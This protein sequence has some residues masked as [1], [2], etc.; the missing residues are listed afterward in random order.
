MGKIKKR[1]GMKLALKIFLT[2]LT[3]LFFG[4]G[5]LAVHTDKKSDETVERWT[6]PMIFGIVGFE[7]VY[8][9]WNA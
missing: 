3:V 8:I 1:F 7:I 5:V 2:V 6:S 4:M 9:I